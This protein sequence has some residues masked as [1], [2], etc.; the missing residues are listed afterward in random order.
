MTEEVQLI[1]PCGMNCSICVS[2]LR[3]ERR[4][5]GCLGKDTKGYKMYYQ[6][7]RDDQAEPVRILL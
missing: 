1:A 5:P 6:K 4:C 2:Y 7:L 3:K